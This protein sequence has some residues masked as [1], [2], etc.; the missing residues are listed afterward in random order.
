MKQITEVGVAVKDLEKATRL[1][2]ADDPRLSHWLYYTALAHFAAERY[3]LAADWG[4]RALEQALG[5]PLTAAS[6]FRPH[7]HLALASYYAHLDR[8]DEARDALEEAR[9]LWPGLRID[10]D[11]EPIFLGRD[12]TLRGRYFDGLRKAGLPEE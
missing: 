6:P 12:P 2:R 4:E 3:E 5:D 9:R 10:R 7:H 1:G 8:L 11:L